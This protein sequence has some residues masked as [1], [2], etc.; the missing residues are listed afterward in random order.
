MRIGPVAAKAWFNNT[1]TNNARETVE[2]SAF[3]ILR[4]GSS[5]S[6]IVPIHSTVDNRERSPVLHRNR[7]GERQ[8]DNLAA[9]TKAADLPLP[10]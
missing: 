3:I 4:H 8:L 5:R 1:R 7:P 10:E 6:R 2:R 9:L